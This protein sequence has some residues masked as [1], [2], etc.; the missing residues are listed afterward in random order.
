MQILTA[1]KRY[2]EALAGLDEGLAGARFQATD[3]YLRLRRRGDAERIY[4]QALASDPDGVRALV[5]L[6]RIALG[7]QDYASAA[8]LALDALE[9]SHHDPGARY[10]LDLLGRALAGMN[11]YVRC[12]RGIPGGDFAE[13]ELPRGPYSAGGTAGESSGRCGVRA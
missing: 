8:R 11:E 9:R 13:S 4:V 2:R 7:R 12:G 6:C 5:G 3:L 1:E 10:L